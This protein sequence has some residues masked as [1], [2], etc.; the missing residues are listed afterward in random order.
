MINVSDSSCAAG[1]FQQNP[2]WAER[3]RRTRRSSLVTQKLTSGMAIP[4]TSQV[5]QHIP[6]YFNESTRNHY[7][8]VNSHKF[9][10]KKQIKNMTSSRLPGFPPGKIFKKNCKKIA[11]KPVLVSPFDSLMQFQLGV[12]LP[13]CCY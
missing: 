7:F 13:P 5:S 4:S 2:W 1:D 6:T 12:Y 3:L 9:H 10:R 11:Y 8:F